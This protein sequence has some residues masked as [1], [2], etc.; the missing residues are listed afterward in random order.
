MAG[1][2]GAA[3]STFGKAL[4]ASSKRKARVRL[5][6]GR[7]LEQVTKF[8]RARQARRAFLRNARQAQAQA[9]LAGVSTGASLESSGAQANLQSLRTQQRVALGEQQTQFTRGAEI[10]R[11]QEAA[12]TQLNQAREIE[13]IT[14]GIGQIGDAIVGA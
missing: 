13:G 5:K 2:V 7:R 3:F 1:I 8:E 14:Q 9:L 4:S 11:L 12:T 6:Q 10:F